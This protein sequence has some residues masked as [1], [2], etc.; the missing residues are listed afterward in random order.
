M[1]AL[2]LDRYLNETVINES[3]VQDVWTLQDESTRKLSES[4]SNETSKRDEHRF[5]RRGEINVNEHFLLASLWMTETSVSLRHYDL[6]RMC[7]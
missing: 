2:R 6:S 3:A 4:K 7:S 1:N 5:A